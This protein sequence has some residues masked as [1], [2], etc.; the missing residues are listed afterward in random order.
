MDLISVCAGLL[1]LFPVPT[2][3][4]SPACLFLAEKISYQL[5][6]FLSTLPPGP[7]QWPLSC[8]R[9]LWVSECPSSQAATTHSAFCIFL[10]FCLRRWGHFKKVDGKSRLMINLLW[11]KKLLKCIHSRS[12]ENVHERYSLWKKYLPFNS[13][14][15]K[16]FEIPWYT[17]HMQRNTHKYTHAPRD[18]VWTQK[19]GHH[20]PIEDS[21]TSAVSLLLLGWRHPPYHILPGPCLLWPESLTL[22]PSVAPLS[23]LSQCSTPALALPQWESSRFL[24]VHPTLCSLSCGFLDCSFIAFIAVCKSFFCVII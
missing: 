12:L 6:P 11:C 13:I 2:L 15:H 14:F 3:H 8:T 10:R 9:R 17:V 16:C 19:S 7:C 22:Q 20:S 5:S 1:W 24:M 18:T 21:L 4:S 23:Q